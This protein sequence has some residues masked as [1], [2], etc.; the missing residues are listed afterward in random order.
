MGVI[1]AARKSGHNYS[2]RRALHSACQSDPRT[3][4]REGAHRRGIQLAAHLSEST[5][6]A[7]YRD[8]LKRFGSLIG[9][10]EPIV[11]HK[12]IPGMGRAK[13]YII[14]IADD[15]RAPLDKLCQKLI[16]AD[17]TCDVLRNPIRQDRY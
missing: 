5:A 9:D 2:T 13:R 8:R 12:E 17:A 4:A 3:E 1:L 11:L 16:A 15:D 10:R 6:W 14:T 7:I